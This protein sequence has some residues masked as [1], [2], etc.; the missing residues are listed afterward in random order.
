MKSTDLAGTLTKIYGRV[1]ANL[2]G[3]VGSD[4]SFRPLFV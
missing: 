2:T 4:W 1:L 3:L